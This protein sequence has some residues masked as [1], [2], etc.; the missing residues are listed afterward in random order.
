MAEIIG[1]V[2]SVAGLLSLSIQIVD[3]TRKLKTKF[4]AIKGLPKTIDKIQRNLEFLRVFLDRAG[5]SSSHLT[6]IAADTRYQLL[7]N[8]CRED[9]SV[10]RDVLEGLERRLEKKMAAKASSLWRP[11][12]RG[13]GAVANEIQRLDQ[14][15]RRAHEHITL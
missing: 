8:T 6:N 9:Y 4:A 3:T 2:A 11:H 1:V 12:V 10:I 13:S 7:L 14:L 15:E 5:E